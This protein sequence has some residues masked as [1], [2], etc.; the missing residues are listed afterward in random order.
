MR[1]TS[2]TIALAFTTALAVSASAQTPA[3][4]PQTPVAAPQ[5]PAAAAAGT[6]AARPSAAPPAIVGGI[7]PPSDYVIGVDDALDIVYWQDKDMS[8]TVT[9]RPDG[10]VS[11]PLLNDLKAAG[12]TP[13]QLRAAITESATKFVE[14]PTVSVVV[15]TINSRKVFLTGQVGKPGPYPLMDSTTTV[16]QMVATAGGPSE[17]AK[18]D[19]ITIVRRE[20]GRDAIHKFNYK[21][22]SQGK[23]LDQNIVLKPGDTIVVP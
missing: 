10:N 21:N 3:A 20:N 15:K 13:E 5:A 1:R 12:L 8:A 2:V 18:T 14:D 7:T 23:G 6:P 16:L 4:V 9:V 19:K 17:Y 11:L 22:V